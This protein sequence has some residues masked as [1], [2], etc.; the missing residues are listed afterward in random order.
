MANTLYLPFLLKKANGTLDLDAAGTVLRCMLERDTSTYA[1]SN[2]H[3]FLSDLTNFVE[4]TSASYARQ[5]IANKAL[6]QD[7]ANNR[8]E[9]DF[10]DPAM[11]AL[12][13]GET[14]KALIFYVQV[15]GDDTTPAD[16]HLVA[17]IDTATGL[18]AVFGGGAVNVTINAEGFI[19]FAQA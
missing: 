16:D 2:Q 8:I 13:V 3:E 6:N 18:P 17:Y 7:N 11:G 9:W 5:T 14:A 4:I 12:E 1:V 10:D 15:G 19:Q